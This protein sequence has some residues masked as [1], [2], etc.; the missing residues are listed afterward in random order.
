M[1]KKA[2]Q[3]ARRRRTIVLASSI[4]QTSDTRSGASG[5][6]LIGKLLSWSSSKGDKDGDEGLLKTVPAHWKQ[7][8]ESLSGGGRHKM[9]R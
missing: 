6:P 4:L 2:L 1:H 9:R 8:L 3:D 5:I 7:H